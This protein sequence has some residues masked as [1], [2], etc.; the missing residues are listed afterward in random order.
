MKKIILKLSGALLFAF[1]TTS[2]IA[3]TPG[4]LTFSYT[5]TSHTGYSGTRNVLAIW[6]S[7]N[8]GTF[9]KTRVRYGG[10]NSTSDHLPTWAVASGGS[11]WNCMSSA[12]NVV[13]ATTGCTLTGYSTKNI[14]WDGT[15]VNGNVVADGLYKVTIESVW[16]HGGSGGAT[17][18]FSFNKN[19]AVDS[20]TPT[21]DANFTNIS[22]TWTPA[23]DAGISD[24]QPSEISIY[25]NPTSGQ[26]KINYK[27][28]D[29]YKVFDLSGKMILAN[30]IGAPAGTID[31]D[32]SD[33]ANGVYMIHV[34][35]GGETSIHKVVLEK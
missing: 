21:D 10:C 3:Q 16:D 11:Q 26:F 19:I 6:I 15:D 22:L 29:A 20:K 1:I 18:S 4:T 8:S 17:R 35:N 25:P 32:L 2:S 31:V 34:I 9:V 23:A 5:P 7:S 27:N 12:C 24:V 28:A 33:Q 30:R 14:T 13:D